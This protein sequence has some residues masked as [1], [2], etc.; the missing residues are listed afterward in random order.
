MELKYIINLI[1]M[2]ITLVNGNFPSLEE[3]IRK[4]ELVL[5]NKL[6]REEVSD[7][8]GSYIMDDQLNFHDNKIWDLLNL[9]FGMDI[10]DSPIDYLHTNEELENWIK[11][12]KEKT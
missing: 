2:V 4:L 11:E 8:A 7:W 9:I 6:T 10:K 3:I 5:E 1:K 12:F